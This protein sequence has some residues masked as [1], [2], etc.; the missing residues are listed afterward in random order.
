MY[1]A[2]KGCQVWIK[3]HMYSIRMYICVYI[4]IPPTRGSL[5]KASRV[6][7]GRSCSDQPDIMQ[8]GTGTDA[9]KGVRFEFRVIATSGMY[10]W[11]VT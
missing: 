2:V 6:R 8:R 4:S 9:V 5:S 3:F 11:L 10:P 1:G 7:R